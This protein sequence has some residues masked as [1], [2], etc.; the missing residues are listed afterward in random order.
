MSQ[1]FS[2]P[3]RRKR[4]RLLFAVWLCPPGFL[5]GV[6]PARG[7]DSIVECD[8]A[9]DFDFSDPDGLTSRVEVATAAFI[10][11]IEAFLRA[12]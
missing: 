9:R 11:D 6:T 10:S 2:T 4:T 8:L 7:I 12:G 5:L 1:A 3:Q